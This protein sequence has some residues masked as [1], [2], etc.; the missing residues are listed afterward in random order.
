MSS[1]HYEDELQTVLGSWAPGDT[2]GM[3]LTQLEALQ[4]L[5]L[6]VYVTAPGKNLEYYCDG[7]AMLG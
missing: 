1:M 2:V 6:P 5:D 7:V 4:A 3:P